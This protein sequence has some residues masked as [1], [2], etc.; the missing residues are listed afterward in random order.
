MV[1]LS[2]GTRMALRADT[3]KIGQL[4]LLFLPRK[5]PS[6]KRLSQMLVFFGL[7]CYSRGVAS[8]RLGLPVWG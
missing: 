3:G 2:G 8:E 7:S 5:N 4:L 1:F 6:V